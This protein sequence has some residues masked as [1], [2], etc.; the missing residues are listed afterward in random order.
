MKAST[1]WLLSHGAPLTIGETVSAGRD[2]CLSVGD[3]PMVHVPAGA[4]VTVTARRVTV[5]VSAGALGG[6]RVLAS[7][8]R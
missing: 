1:V 5:T 3:A 6:A 7:I 8:R 4:T 2:S